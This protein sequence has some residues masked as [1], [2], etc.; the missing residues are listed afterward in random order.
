MA[1]A[2]GFVLSEAKDLLALSAAIEDV[3]S[4]IIPNPPPGWTLVLDPPEVGP[5]QNKWQLWKR[6]DGAFAIVARDHPA[7]GKHP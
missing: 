7:G 2:S 4:P 6:N 1:F 3:I 5:F